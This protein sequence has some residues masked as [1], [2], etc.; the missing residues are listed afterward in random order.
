LFSLKS[1]PRAGEPKKSFLVVVVVVGGVRGSFVSWE[2]VG[3]SEEDLGY[4][5]FRQGSLV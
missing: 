5:L 4:H 3:T 1:K 2:I